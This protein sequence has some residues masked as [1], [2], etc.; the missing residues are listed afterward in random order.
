MRLRPSS[1]W[2][3]G[4]A[5]VESKTATDTRMTQEPLNPSSHRVNAFFGQGLKVPQG[6]SRRAGE[7]ARLRLGAG[8]K[9]RAVAL[10]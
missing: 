2:N 1:P 4:R 6:F 3:L 9:G 10:G 5:T 8:D 7:A